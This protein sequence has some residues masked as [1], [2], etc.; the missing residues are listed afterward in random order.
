MAYPAEMQGSIKKV[1]ASRSRRKAQTFSRLDTTEKTALLEAYHPDFF[2][3]QKREIRLGAN[4]RDWAPKEL[5]EMLESPSRLIPDAVNLTKV[6]YKT[7]ILIIGG[8]GA[9]VT[10]APDPRRP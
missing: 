6:D 10:A 2:K 9:A 3:S 4:K 8:G 1:E 7:D 5:V